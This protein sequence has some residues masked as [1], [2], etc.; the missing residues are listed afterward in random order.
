MSKNWIN[1]YGFGQARSWD[2]LVA[3]LVLIMILVFN[4]IQEE[5]IL[6]LADKMILDE[7]S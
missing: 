3:L 1:V 7:I 5:L 2:A 6:V 4:R